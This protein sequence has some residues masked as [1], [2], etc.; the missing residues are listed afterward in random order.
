MRYEEKYNLRE[1]VEYVASVA[2]V[3]HMVLVSLVQRNTKKKKK[4]LINTG[5][6]VQKKEFVR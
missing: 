4:L 1:W 2:P 3:A 6:N 5:V